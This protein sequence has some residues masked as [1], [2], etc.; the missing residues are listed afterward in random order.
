MNDETAS[1]ADL[2]VLIVDDNVDAATSLSYLLQMIGCKT[3]VAFGGEMGLRVTELFQPALLLIDLNMP[4]L[5]GCEMLA[6]IKAIPG[7]PALAMAVCLSGTSQAG[8]EER[9]RHAGFDLFAVKPLE[10]QALSEL[11]ASAR[12]RQAMLSSG[13]PLP[14]GADRR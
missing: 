14:V 1:M 12:A 11:L 13:R 9:C 7:R 4:G 2:R 8:D 10:P 6:R 5:D 3:A